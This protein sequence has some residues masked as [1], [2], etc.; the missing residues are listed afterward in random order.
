MEAG[1]FLCAARS[2]WPKVPMAKSSNKEGAPDR[3]RINMNE[4]DEVRYW[5]EALGCSTDELAVAVARVGTSPDAVLREIH[6][7]WAYGTFRQGNTRKAEVARRR[8]GRP[9]KQT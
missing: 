7:H 8:R 6:R 3:S 5:T 1:L 2:I 9:R 4:A